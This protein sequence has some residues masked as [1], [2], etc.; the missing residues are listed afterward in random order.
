M[1]VSPSRKKNVV[2]NRKA[3]VNRFNYQEQCLKLPKKMLLGVASNTSTSTQAARVR[4][5]EKYSF[6]DALIWGSQPETTENTVLVY[7]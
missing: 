7:F 6:L 4:W 5:A 3:M 2:R 1:I